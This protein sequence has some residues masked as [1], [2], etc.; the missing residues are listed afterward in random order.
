[1]NLINELPKS[2]MLNSCIEVYGITEIVYVSP[3]E[4]EYRSKMHIDEITK[5][6]LDSIVHRYVLKSKF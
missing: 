2:N 3:F 1:M 4:V 6:N 5:L